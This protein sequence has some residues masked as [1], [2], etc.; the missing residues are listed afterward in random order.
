MSPRPNNGKPDPR[1]ADRQT[2]AYLSVNGQGAGPDK[3]TVAHIKDVVLRSWQVVRDADDLSPDNPAISAALTELVDTVAQRHDMATVRAV[4]DAPEIRQIMKPMWQKL[5]EAEGAME[6]WWAKRFN[7]ARKLH[8]EKGMKKSDSDAA[9]DDFWYRDNYTE[10]TQLEVKHWAGQGKAPTKDSHVVFIGSG[11]LPMT[12]I[13]LHL[14]TGANITCV[15]SD[16]EAVR[17]SRAL[18]RKLNL[19]RAITV[20]EGKG[21]E[22]DYRGVT[23]AMVAALVPE[24]PKTVAKVLADSPNAMIGVRSA[25]GLRTILYPPAD[26][27][28]LKAM[29]LHYTGASAVN[30]RVINTL[31]TFNP[32]PKLNLDQIPPAPKK[33][34]AS[35]D[36]TGCATRLGMM[37]LGN[38]PRPGRPGRPGR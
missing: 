37:G 1:D 26:T 6:M 16:P 35:C 20:V 24:Q 12:A 23:H 21:E 18:L 8:L 17:Q 10:L 38:D 2:P 4:V 36:N 22:V 9:L 33:N 28:A 19:D 14:Q 3:A 13:D 27:R 34:C 15:D 5:S 30:E 29:G 25:S 11:P 31:L 7:S 32:G